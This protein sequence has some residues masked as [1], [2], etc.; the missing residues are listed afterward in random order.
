[1]DANRFLTHSLQDPRVTRI[2]AAALDAVEPAKLVRDYLQKAD[3][4]KY[5]RVF[6]LG[7]GKAAEPM[8]VAAADILTHFADALIVTK[9]ASGRTFSRVTVMEGGHPIPDE[10]S[11]AAGQA[12]FDFVSKLNENDLLICLISGGGSALVTLPYYGV[13]LENIQE[14]TSILLACGATIDEINTFRRL[15]DKLKGGRL[16]RATKAKVLSLILS[17]VP[18]DRL[19][20]I[21]S[22]LTAR[23]PT[24]QMT[25][26]DILRKYDIE[27]KLP[28]AILGGIILQ[29]SIIDDSIFQTRV[30]N[31]IVGNNRTAANAAKVQAEREGFYSEIIGLE[32]Q[33]EAR[34]VGE[35]L[36]ETLFAV[37]GNRP[38]PFCLIAGGETTVTIKGNG[39]G[40]RNQELALAAVNPLRGVENILFISLAT[41][42][43]DGP[44]DA[45][46]AA[47]NGESYQRA[48]KLGMDAS[49]YLSR[50]DAYNFFDPLDDLLKPGYTG[51]NVNDLVFLI[52]L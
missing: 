50:N 28:K 2:L 42:G 38:G 19:E 30:Q 20:T 7:I 16:A 43:D 4:P 18:G 36:A 10:R 47:V 34:S 9:H 3:L 40:G 11:L 26:I 5:D 17:D 35:K 13:S 31:I 1:M 29:P 21:A 46:G 41:D 25:A 37:S 49:D 33:G 48:K 15:F 23:D 44:T 51:T 24:D 32:I 39:K 12:V 6:L 52:G 14:L 45:A 27:Y 8:T 22:G